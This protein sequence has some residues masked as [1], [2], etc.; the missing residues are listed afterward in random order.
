MYGMLLSHM[1]LFLRKAEVGNQSYH[2]R[3]ET[4][5]DNEEP[6]YPPPALE[7]I[8]ETIQQYDRGALICLAPINPTNELNRARLV[9]LAI[10]LYRHDAEAGHCLENAYI[11]VVLDLNPMYGSRSSFEDFPRWSYLDRADFS[12]IY[13]TRSGTVVYNGFLGP[14]FL[15]DQEGLGTGRLSLVEFNQNGTVKHA[16]PIRPFNMRWPYMDLTVNGKEI[17]EIVCSDGGKKHQNTPINMDLPILD[18][19]TSAKEANQ[20]DA[21][22]ALCNREQWTEDVE[23]YAPGYLALEA[24]GREADYNLSNLVDP[25]S[26]RGV[27]KRIWDKLK[28]NQVSGFTYLPS[29]PE[30]KRREILGSRAPPMDFQAMLKRLSQGHQD[31]RGG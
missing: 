16:I 31:G 4:P 27:K 14:Y 26:L 19:L 22:T 28:G 25:E 13:L 10:L 5:A 7:R 8:Q 17:E 23:L 3:A 24:Q 6:R 12:S 1:I 15:I 30:A 18:I 21:D 29:V 9:K 20:L 11:P 2:T